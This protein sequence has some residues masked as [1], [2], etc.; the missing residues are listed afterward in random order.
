MPSPVLKA[1]EF[2]VLEIC[3]RE[4][5]STTKS[6]P[7]AITRADFDGLAT[8]ISARFDRLEASTSSRGKWLQSPLGSAIVGGAVV[9]L[10]FLS[11]GG[12]IR[13]IRIKTPR[14]R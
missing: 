14:R 2:E 11:W 6:K 7:A 12:L 1:L 13:D 5:M 9:S 4:D 8:S 10:A 3:A